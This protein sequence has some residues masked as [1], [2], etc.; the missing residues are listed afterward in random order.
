MERRAEPAGCERVINAM[1]QAVERGTSLCRQLLAFA[2]RQPLR[3]EPV[4]LNRLIVGMR[5]LLDRSLRGDVQ[6]QSEFG[7]DLWPG[8]ADPARLVLVIL[9]RPVNWGDATPA[10]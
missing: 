9:R 5:E 4:D 10:G 1:K 7:E 6:F 8:E 3:P 2:R